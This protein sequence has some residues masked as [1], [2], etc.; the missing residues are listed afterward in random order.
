MGARSSGR[1]AKPDGPTTVVDSSDEAAGNQKEGARL[2]RHSLINVVGRLMIGAIGIVLI[3]IMLDGLGAEMYG[4]WIAALALYELL[5][6]IDLGLG[7]SLTKE[8]AREPQGAAT[9]QFAQSAANALVL[10]GLIGAV[11]L[12]TAGYLM[13]GRLSVG[14]DGQLVAPVVFLILGLAF[15]GEALIGYLTA[16]LYGLRQFGRVTALFVGLA[17]GRGA[18]FIALLVSGHGVLWLAAWYTF[19]TWLAAVLGMLALARSHP[20]FRFRPGRLDPEILRRHAVFSLA[21]QVT[22]LGTSAIWKAPTLM[23]GLIRNAAAI[24]PYHIGQRL[25]IV[26]YSIGWRAAEAVFPAA[27]QHQ[28]AENLKQTRQALFISTR[29]SILLTLPLLLIM[30]GI[31]PWFLELW[32]GSASAEVVAVMR[33]TAGTVLAHLLGASALHMLWGRGR[34]IQVSLILGGMAVAIIVM[35]WFLVPELGA[36]GAAWSALIPMFLGSLL[37][38]K[39]AGDQCGTSFLEVLRQALRGLLIPSALTLLAVVLLGEWL[40]SGGWLPMV[41]S[42]GTAGLLFVVTFYAFG[43]EEEERQLL[44]HVFFGRTLRDD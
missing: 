11:F 43:S 1:S 6:S 4:V 9:A 41:I 2:I 29:W 20:T 33:V 5:A 24:V 19:S 16:I 28:A 37:L 14:A 32:L 13:T 36:L 34:S 31:A 30:S 38:V 23:L 17:L 40:G 8:V 10:L 21:S 3:P 18:G 39:F 42:C 44:L 7:W 15:V 26:A 12:T 22:A 27:S 35:A 25:P